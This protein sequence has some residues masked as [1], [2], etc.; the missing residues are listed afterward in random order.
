MLHILMLAVTLTLMGCG[1]LSF[2]GLGLDVFTSGSVQEPEPGPLSA[3]PGVA[4]E[5]VEACR[6]A[7]AAAAAHHGATRVEAV[8]AGQVTQLPDGLTEAP[9]D[10]RIVYDEA[11]GTQVRQARVTCRLDEQGSVVGLL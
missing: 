9:I 3:V 5:T 8:S 11:A 4:D 2:R 1:P 10:A 6:Q 7:M